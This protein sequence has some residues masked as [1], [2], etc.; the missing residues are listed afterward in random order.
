MEGPGDAGLHLHPG[1]GSR[2]LSERVQAVYGF[3]RSVHRQARRLLS[4]AVELGRDRGDALGPPPRRRL[5]DRADRVCG[6]SCGRG[7]V[8]RQG[9]R[10]GPARLSADFYRARGQPLPEARRSQGQARR[11]HL[12]VIEFRAPC[13]ARAL[14]ARGTQAER[15][16]QAVDVGRARQVRARRRLRRLRHGRRRLRR[17]RTHGH[18]RNPQGG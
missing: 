8:R 2:G 4:G 17:V 3:P 18:A 5:L 11:A 15:G 1:R 16:L 6:E 12:A 13:P 10:E 7:A 14:S 9:H